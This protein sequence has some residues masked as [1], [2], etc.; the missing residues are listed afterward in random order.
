[1]WDD[2][3]IINRISSFL[4]V[5]SVAGLVIGLFSI[6][7]Q[8]ERFEIKKIIVKGDLHEDTKKYLQRVIRDQLTGG[9]LTISL[10]NSKQI[11]EQIPRVRAVNISRKWPN[12]LEINVVEHS[13]LAKWGE[14]RFV[15]NVGQIIEAT[16]SKSKSDNLP[17][18]QGPD[19]IAS[20]TVN[21]YLRGNQILE[22]SGREIVSIKVNNRYAWEVK[23]DNEIVLRI[24]KEKHLRRLMMFVK[25]YKFAEAASDKKINYLDLRYEDGFAVGT[26]S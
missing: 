24:G 10:S 11:L 1:M 8:L 16:A 3:R 14:N 20:E 18:F 22:S 4:I 21:L 5:L 6:I 7:S 2:P 9:F 17:F 23:L 25:L 26:K 19:N 15:N 13:P 12:V